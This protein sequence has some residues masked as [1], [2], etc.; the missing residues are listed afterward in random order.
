MEFF[1]IADVFECCVLARSTFLQLAIVKIQIIFTE[2]ILSVEF[3]SLFLTTGKKNPK[4]SKSHYK[5]TILSSKHVTYKVSLIN[6]LNFLS[7]CMQI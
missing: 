6:S 7:I 2:L 3:I 1:R 5:F 4:H